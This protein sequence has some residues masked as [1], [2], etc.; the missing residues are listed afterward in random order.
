M[1]LI[2]VCGLALLAVPCASAADKDASSS[3]TATANFKAM[4]TDSDG[5]ISPAEFAAGEEMKK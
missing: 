1:T 3:S 5:R 2:V 4:D